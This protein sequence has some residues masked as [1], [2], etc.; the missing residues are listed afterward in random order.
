MSSY[1]VQVEPRRGKRYLAPTRDVGHIFR[2]FRDACAMAESKS[3]DDSIVA[4]RVIQ[5]ND[6]PPSSILGLAVYQNGVKTYPVPARKPEPRK[7][8]K[9]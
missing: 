4:C 1:A 7:S 6:K 3:N 2:L 5:V 8:S 9:P